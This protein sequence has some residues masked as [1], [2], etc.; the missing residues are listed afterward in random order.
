[1]FLLILDDIVDILRFS[2]QV[3]AT[4][5]APSETATDMM[6]KEFFKCKQ[7]NDDANQ[8]LPTSEDEL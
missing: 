4:G 8:Q 6:C 7:E 3:A 5:M 2:G 1:M